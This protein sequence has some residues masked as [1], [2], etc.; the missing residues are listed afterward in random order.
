LQVLHWRRPPDRPHI[1]G[2]GQ[3]LKTS[4]PTGELFDA[5]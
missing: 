3:G 5:I 4:Y 2:I 1:T